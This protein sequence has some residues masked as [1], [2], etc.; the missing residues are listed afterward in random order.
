MHARTA[1]GKGEFPLE[2]GICRVQ[3]VELLKHF[4]GA[5]C[6]EVA[7]FS[8]MGNHYHAVVRFEGYREMDRE[9]L[10]ERALV[11]Y[12][13]SE[14][15]LGVWGEEKWERFN[16]RLFDVSELM[17]NVQAAFARWYNRTFERRGRF[18]ADRFKSTLLE[19]GRAV[20]DCMLYVDL[21][22]VRA[23]MVTRPEEH[24]GSS[25][26][27]RQAQKGRWLLGLRE[28]VGSDGGSGG[29]GIEV[30]GDAGGKGG[31]SERKAMKAYRGL[32]YYRGA[33]P[34][35][36]GQGAIP[37]AIVRAE[38]ARGFEG[39]G[40]YKERL[41]FFAEG[42]AV[43]SEGFVREQLAR[44]RDAGVYLRR[45][46]PIQLPVGGRCMALREQRSHAVAF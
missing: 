44:L 23:G 42:V 27:Y 37:E 2:R 1:G 15:A 46:N 11:L 10:R 41:R 26:Y 9:E 31:N 40:A 21:N 12:P 17:R 33:V 29:G 38:E 16:R 30:G 35:K 36:E 34:T 28:V 19:P 32:L 6:C 8:V 5:Y 14:G 4:C 24:A 3:L 13:N 43:G 22:G 45:K 20:V 39:K 7:A 25:I 18:W